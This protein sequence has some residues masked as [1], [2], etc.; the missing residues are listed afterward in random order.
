MTDKTPPLRFLLGAAAV[1]VTLVG[2]GLWQ[3]KGWLAVAEMRNLHAARLALPPIALPADA[4]RPALWVFRHVQVEGKFLHEH[5]IVVP[6]GPLDGRAG[7]HVVTPLALNKGGTLL[8]DRGWV[9]PERKD[10]ASRPEAMPASA[11]TGVLRLPQS[12][13]LFT[14]D[15]RDQAWHRIDPPA[16]G[17]AKGLAGVLPY[18]LELDAGQAGPEGPRGGHLLPEAPTRSLLFA[19]SWFALAAFVAAVVAIRLRR[20]GG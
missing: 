10:P 20:K 8:V 3:M 7:Y 18:Y 16:M 12:R 15:N 5:E 1:F 2:L 6:S 19:G 17:A 14:P 9:P 4:A 11:L 13:A